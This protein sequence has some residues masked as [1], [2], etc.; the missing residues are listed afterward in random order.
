LNK[1]IHKISLDIESR[2]INYRR[3]FHKYAESGWTEFFTTS[4][5][6]DKLEK[7][8]YEIITTKE[9]MKNIYRMGVPDSDVL[10]FHYKRALNQGANPK[11]MKKLEGGYTGAIG[12]I[13]RGE[14]PTIALRFDID[15][16]DVSESNSVDHFPNIH[17]FTSV[18]TG[19]MHAC[20]H[21]GH[22]AIGLG[23]AEVISKIA[24][25]ING[26]II[27]IFQPAEEG[28]RGAKSIAS[29]E[30]LNNVDYL[31]GG[32]LGIKK[33]TSKEL[34][35]NLEGFLATTKIDAH[36]KGISTHAGVSPE[37]GRNAL[38]AAASSSIHLSSI[39]RNSQGAT[40]INIG[41]LEAGTGR[42]VIPGYAYMQLET[43]GENSDLN[44]YMKNNALN[45]LES[46]AKMYQVNLETKVMGEA[47]AGHNNKKLVDIIEKIAFDTK[48]F[49]KV[50]KKSIN[51]GGS[52]DFSYLMDKVQKKGGEA[53]YM[54]FGSDIK[55]SHHHQG[56]DFQEKDLI[57]IV[58]LLSTITFK[59]LEKA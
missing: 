31:L 44:E 6:I 37:V 24:D 3:T 18:N 2:V 47:K 14:G 17:N 5:I 55:E 11:I 22:A 42:N 32:H 59:L 26:T 9:I 40:R 49:T 1:K 8:G 54:L 35:C 45:I 21:D 56:F 16:V 25:Q 39:P 29:S 52:E 58:E 23:V 15:A 34:Y 51:L 20:G 33:D 43:R 30:I 27:L 12:I 28:V 50:S 48:L 57:N 36:F 7:L 41:K 46:S 4:T 10:D 13:K 19:V 53:S 38:L